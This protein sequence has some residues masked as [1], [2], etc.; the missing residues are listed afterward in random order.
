MCGPTGPGFC[1]LRNL[2][3]MNQSLQFLHFGAASS[4]TCLTQVGS[5]IKTRG[6][7]PS[8]CLTLGGMVVLAVSG[9]GTKS[10]TA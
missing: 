6:S 4:K 3:W 2:T 10:R 8:V 9:T 1:N 5:K 7:L